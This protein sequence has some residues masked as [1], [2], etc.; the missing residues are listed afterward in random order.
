MAR[1]RQ[2]DPGARSRE[3]QRIAGRESHTD[4]PSSQT[5]LIDPTKS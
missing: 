3:Y 5:S 1:P 4:M 2:I